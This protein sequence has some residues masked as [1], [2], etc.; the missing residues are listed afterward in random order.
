MKLKIIRQLLIM[1]KYF[2]YAFFIQAFFSSMLLANEGM[3]QKSIHEI[4]LSIAFDEQ[5]MSEVFETLHN[6]TG[7]YFTYNHKEFNKGQRIS[8]NF[9]NE[10]LGD[11]LSFISHKM[12]LAFKRV[13]KNIYVRK[14][15]N[16]NDQVVEEEISPVQ[17]TI[18]G[19]VTSL[20]DNEPLPGVSIL[21]KGTSNGTTTD[22]DG[23]YSLSANENDVLQFSYIGYQTK[24]LTLNDQ[25]VINIALE[26]DLEQLEEVV[27]IG[28]GT[29]KKS[30]LTG[31]VGSIGSKEIKAQPINAVNQALQGRVTGV[32]V[33]QSSNAPGGGITIR[34]RGGNSISAS[35]D[36]LYVIDGFPITNPSPASGASNS[37]SYPN[38]LSSINPSDIES[39]EVLK[40]ASATAIYGSRGANGVVIITTKRG[41]EG[42]STVDFD[43]YYG[44]QQVT[45]TLDLITAEEH[46]SLKNEQLRNLGFTE[47]YG[48]PNGNYPRTPA[49]Y[50]KGTD[51]QDEIFR[52]APIQNYQLTFSGGTEKLRYLISGNYFNQ[53]G[54]VISSNFKRYTSRIN[55]DATISDKFK[56]GSNFTVSHSI[57]NGV[58]E[59]GTNGV[60]GAA[61]TRS[62][63][64][65]VYDED[66]NYTL[67]NVGPGSGFSNYPNPVAVANTSTNLLK[68]NRVLGNIFGEYTIFEGLKARISIGADILNTR[69]DIFYTPE[70]LI[71]NNLNGYG[72]NGNSNNINLLNEN[73]L[74]YTK[75]LDNHAF[76]IVAGIT[77]QNN[78]EERTYSEAQ[79]FPNYTLGANN[80]GLANQPLP[81]SGSVSEWG[82]NSYLGRF[83]YRFKDRYLFTITGRVDGS[84]RF[85]ANNKYGFF[86]SGAFAWRVSDEEFLQGNRLINDLKFRVSYGITGNDGIGLYNSLSQYST[87]RT[88]FGDV[89]VLTI[90][91]SRIANP[92]LK[93]EKTAQFNTG[94]D[95]GFFD[96]R[97]Q[98]TA[99]YYIKTTTD[100]LLG[101]Q[102]PSTTGFTSVTR[103][104][105]SLENRGFELGINTVNVDGEF[106]WTTNGNISFNKNKVLK[107]NDADQFLVGSTSGGG[108][109]IVKVGESVGSFYGN[110]FDGIWQTETEIA[111]A[112]DIARAGDLPGAL[113]YK[114]LDGDGIFNPAADRTILGNGLPDFIFGL[115]NNF[116]FKE[117]DL[118]I[119][120]QGVQGNEILNST[121][122]V[123]ERSDPSSALLRTVYEGA[124]RADN[125]S[126]NHPSIRQWRSTNTD[127]YYIEDGSFVR[128][129]N[130]SLGYNIPL[131]SKTISNARVY[132]SGQNLITFTNYRGYDP[133]VNSD[134]N[135][136]TNYG[137]DVFAYPAARTY[138]I[139]ASLSF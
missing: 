116:S 123:L 118:S 32:Q 111:E 63:A 15:K 108:T 24:E 69:K 114:D 12:N 1:S 9:K 71:G 46:T 7:F 6:E 97:L 89:E 131:Q 43:A 56:V 70:T 20:E 117:F 126:N 94:V 121:R 128:L 4:K 77:F 29:Q 122:S 110:V 78:R 109:S 132:I 61:L 93:W 129:K 74:S 55:L 45:K 42:R 35:N 28:Y 101:V 58:N 68:T 51:W 83:N 16:I 40:D 90:E 87:S 27:V 49:E 8:G 44:L 137:V 85:G 25:S 75:S 76:D 103:N 127:S 33:T 60:V 73:T 18:T 37:N 64:S 92:D 107:L 136:N 84:S 133:E 19:K 134:F 14:V 65:D 105:G 79:D 41:K 67:L 100:L 38:P 53:D 66:G 50:G 17:V 125:P 36:P 106:K 59:T 22:I 31:S 99:D 21:I 2:L 30:D 13:N 72:S 115:T 91:A 26:A 96:S 5:N 52:V 47:R 81:P 119:F 54:I 48:N 102:L 62:P 95:I 23:R 88:V 57:N 124:W 86:P 135:S 138:T 104:V 113:R 10:S 98:I 34:V 112:G 11:V 39:I 130:V 80:L 139:G 82:L 3:S 120:L